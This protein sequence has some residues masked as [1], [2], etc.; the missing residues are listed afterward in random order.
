MNGVVNVA[1][2]TRK[3]NIQSE[4]DVS[5]TT[6]QRKNVDLTPAVSILPMNSKDQKSK[7]NSGEGPR[8]LSPTSAMDVDLTQAVNILP[9]NSKVQEFRDDSGEGPRL[10]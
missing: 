1:G 10:P 5:K 6:N 7:G 4:C 9:M 3:E 2:G 8:L